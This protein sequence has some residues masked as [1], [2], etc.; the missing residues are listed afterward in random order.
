ME[1]KVRHCEGSDEKFLFPDKIMRMP[2]KTKHLWKSAV[3][4]NESDL[5]E[6]SLKQRVWRCWGYIA[7]NSAIKFV[8]KFCSTN[9]RGRTEATSMTKLRLLLS[10]MREWQLCTV[11]N[12][13]MK[14]VLVTNKRRR[15]RMCLENWLRLSKSRWPGICAYLWSACIWK[16]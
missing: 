5:V 7:M 4:Y 12:W 10:R 3:A 16:R 15:S 6:S 1:S 13:R 14:R 9:G 8:K 11:L 2:R